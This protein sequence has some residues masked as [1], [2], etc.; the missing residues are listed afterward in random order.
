MR[1][2]LLC[3]LLTA[4]VAGCTPAARV[5]LQCVD[6]DAELC[7]AAWELAQPHLLPEETALQDVFINRVGGAATCVP[8]PCPEQIAATAYYDAGVLQ[9]VIL[10]VTGGLRVVDARRVVLARPPTDGGKPEQPPEQP[11]EGIESISRPVRN[12]R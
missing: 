3:V 12:V 6:L 11:P 2:P 9:E 10:Q 4:A 8:G 7:D 5:E 1:F